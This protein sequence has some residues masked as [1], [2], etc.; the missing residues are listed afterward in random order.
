LV[1]RAFIS[2]Y[3]LRYIEHT[4]RD[5]IR[6]ITTYDY[7]DL[8][9]DHPLV[10]IQQSDD[11][12]SELEEGSLYLVDTNQKLYLLRPLFSRLQCPECGLWATF[13][14]DKYDKSENSVLLKSLEHGHTAKDKDPS[15]VFLF[16]RWG[17]LE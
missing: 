10:P 9:G 6:K 5:S 13:F 14:L 7:R 17:F 3:P 12:D 11:T 1:G 15:S 4:K 8:M 2:D 16:K